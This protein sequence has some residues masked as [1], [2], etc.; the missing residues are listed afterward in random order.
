MPWDIQRGVWQEP[1]DSLDAY[2]ERYGGS[3]GFK[4]FRARANHAGPPRS[5][6]KNRPIHRPHYTDERFRGGRE[7][8]LYGASKP[9]LAYE[10]S[11][12]L[13]QWDYDKAQAASATATERGFANGSPAWYEDY[14]STYHGKPVELLHIIGGVNASSGYEYFVF[15]F[16]DAQQEGE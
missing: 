4:R 9:G 3:N 7:H 6:S 5:L 10:Y 15:G 14:L 11:D 12:R 8:T 1:D 16:R 2:A 13:W